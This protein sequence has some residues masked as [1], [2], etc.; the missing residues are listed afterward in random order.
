VTLGDE[1]KKFFHAN[2]IVRHNKN[3]IM[4]LK[5]A[6]GLEKFSHD[7]KANILWEAYKE[8]LETKEFT[9]MY[10]DLSNLLNRVHNLDDLALPF[11]KEEIVGV[12]RGL[13]LDKYLGPDGF[14]TDFMKKCWS[15][16]CEDFYE[17]CLAFYNK[18]VCLQSING[19]YITLIPKIDNPV[20]VSDF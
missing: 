11:S 7:D 6:D 5:G 17:L 1:N 16:I 8:R 12:I 14:N 10:F 4:S 3:S 9:H 18:E 19:S 13:P 15:V 2:A 20:T